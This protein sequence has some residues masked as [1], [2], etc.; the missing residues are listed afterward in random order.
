MSAEEYIKK[1][2]P[3]TYERYLNYCRKDRIPK[4][5]TIVKTLKGGFGSIDAGRILLIYKI[6]EQYVVLANPNWK[7]ELDD[8]DIENGINEP[9]DTYASNIKDWWKELQIVDEKR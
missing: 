8:W 6:N 4:A 9:Q 2:E 5:G 1:H 3:D 7:D